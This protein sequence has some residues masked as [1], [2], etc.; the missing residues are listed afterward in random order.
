[1]YRQERWVALGAGGSGKD[2]VQ[3]GMGRRARASPQDQLAA[4][5]SCIRVHKRQPG[6]I[7]LRARPP[8]ACWSCT[9]RP[10]DRGSRP[11]STPSVQDQCARPPAGGCRRKSP[12]GWGVFTALSNVR[13]G[14]TVRS[15]SPRSSWLPGDLALE[16]SAFPTL[17]GP[18]DRREFLGQLGADIG[19]AMRLLSPPGR[20]LSSAQAA[21]WRLKSQQRS[22]L[23]AVV[24]ALR[25][26][27]SCDGLEARFV[28]PVG[29]A[30]QGRR[31][32]S[33]HALQCGAS[34]IHELSIW[35]SMAIDT[36][37]ETVILRT[38]RPPA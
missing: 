4:M 36:L 33:A 8:T 34:A 32:S 17:A 16:T 19:M 6:P 9:E 15:R 3:A 24:A 13:Q 1:M 14:L 2:R 35:S 11:E 30:R 20:G 5:L 22:H 21:G 10:A 18:G 23:I 31:R 29:R 12:P 26:G 7:P 25:P 27:A 28:Q 38:A 37:A